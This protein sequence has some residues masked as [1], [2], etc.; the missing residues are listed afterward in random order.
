MARRRNACGAAVMMA[1]RRNTG[2]SQVMRVARC[3]RGHWRRGTASGSGW[4]RVVVQLRKYV[5]DHGRGM[6]GCEGAVGRHT[7]GAT[8]RVGRRRAPTRDEQ[9]RA[10][11]ATAARFARPRAD[12]MPGGR[13]G[14]PATAAGRRRRGRAEQTADLKIPPIG[15]KQG[16]TKL[17][18]AGAKQAAP[19]TAPALSLSHE[20]RPTLTRDRENSSIGI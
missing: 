6:L 20:T 17:D 14:G 18:T 4:P 9:S 2:R 5:C 15:D 7:Q 19:A 12:A 3:R 10:S 8:N 11:R 13:T 16:A 1:Q